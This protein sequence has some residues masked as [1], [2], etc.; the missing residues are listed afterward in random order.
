VDKLLCEGLED[1]VGAKWAFEPD[2]NKMA[3]L[4]IDHIEKKRDAL[5]INVKK[6]RKLYDMA[7]RRALD[8]E[9]LTAAQAGCEPGIAHSHQKKD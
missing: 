1:I 4:M 3:Q 5:G 2:V 8:A 7:D 6:E 9:N